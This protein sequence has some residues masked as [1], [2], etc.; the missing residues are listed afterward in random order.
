MLSCEACE[1]RILN[2]SCNLFRLLIVNRNNLEMSTRMKG[3]VGGK[4]HYVL[5]FCLSLVG[6]SLF[7]YLS[8]SVPPFQT[9][10]NWFDP[11]SV[12]LPAALLFITHNTCTYT[13]SQAERNHFFLYS[14]S[15]QASR[16]FCLAACIGAC[17]I[18]QFDYSI[19]LF[20]KSLNCAD[21]N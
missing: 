6:Q 14:G 18:L 1:R 2:A 21:V 11:N 13:P 10:N 15:Q 5:A 16:F 17:Q 20:S 8:L 4:G 3:G 12:S 19:S 7:L 9:V